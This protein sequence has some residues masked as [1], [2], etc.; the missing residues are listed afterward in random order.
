[1]HRSDAKTTA[2]GH[3]PGG[4]TLIELLVVI[5]I[6]AILVGLLIPAVQAARSAARRTYC[7]NNLRQLGIGLHGYQAALGSLPMAITGSLDTRY[8]IGHSA[9]CQSN[10]YNESYLVAVLPYLEQSTLYNA[11]N[12]QLFVLSLDNLTAT[13]A[14]VATFVCPDDVDAATAQPISLSETLQLGYDAASP[15]RMGRTSYVAVAG[16]LPAFATPIGETFAV[17]WSDPGANGAFGTPQPVGFAAITDGLSTTMLASERSLTR[18]RLLTTFASDEFRSSSLW[19]SSRA[20]STLASARRPPLRLGDVDPFHAGTSAM[21]PGGVHVLMADGSARF[22]KDSVDSWP[23]DNSR[24]ADI[25]AGRVPPGVWQKL[26]TRAGGEVVDT[27]S[28]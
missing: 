8:N 10:L 23:A 20:Q 22:V 28:F 9:D 3:R 6:I 5:S 7:L 12:H 21:H 11:L 16:S 27:T 13:S 2:R 15:P 26:A 24:D 18:L 17:P 14:T 25:F 4:F 1:M 19:A